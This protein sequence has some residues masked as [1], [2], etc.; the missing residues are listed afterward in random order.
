MLQAICRRGPGAARRGALLA[1][2]YLHGE[3][4]LDARDL[5]AVQRLIRVKAARDVPYALDVCFNN[6]LA[7]RGGMSVH[8]VITDNEGYAKL[9]LKK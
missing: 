9:S 7:I 8:L 4:G 3:A 1:S 2:V 5:A 6:W